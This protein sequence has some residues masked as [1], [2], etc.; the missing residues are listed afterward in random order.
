VRGLYEFSAFLSV[1]G[2][3]LIVRPAIPFVPGES[4]SVSCDDAA[5]SPDA[6]AFEYSFSVSSQSIKQLNRY[7]TAASEDPCIP[8]KAP[9]GPSR[10]AAPDARRTTGA[11]GVSVPSDYP[12]VTV[13]K[14]T[15]PSDGKVFINNWGGTPYI[16]ILENNGDPVFYRRTP[17]RARDF[18]VQP[19]GL[20]TYRLGPPQNVFHGMD[21]TYA[22]TDTFYAGHGYGTDEHDL[23]ILP[24]G[25]ALV[26]ALDHQQIDM[27]VLVPGGRT[28][29]VVIGNHIQE[30]DK[31]HNV[32]FEWRSWDNFE[33]TDARHIDLT[34][35]TIDYVHMNSISVDTDGNIIISSR[36]LSEI[37]K[38]DRSTGTVMWRLGGA[39]NQFTFAGMEGPFSWQHDARALG[40]NTYTIFDNGNWNSPRETRVLEYNLDTTNRGATLVWE[41]RHTPAFYTWWMG[42][43]QRLPGGN[44]VIGWADASLPRLTEVTPAGETVLEL[45]FATP[46]HCYRVFK[47]PWEGKASAPYLTAEPLSVGARLLFPVFGDSSI[48]KYYIYAGRSAHPTTLV[49]SSIVPSI[50]VTGLDTGNHYFRVTAVDGSGK[51]TAFSNEE[52]VYVRNTVPGANLVMNG[53][54]D[55]GVAPWTLNVNG[56]GVATSTVTDGGEYFIGISGGGTQVWNVQL[57]QGNIPLLQGRR[58]IF[59]FDA[60]AESPRTIDA[61]MEQDGGSYINYSR[62][63]AVYIT[64]SMTRINIPF[65][66]QD[67]TDMAARVSLNCGQSTVNVFFDNISVRED[68]ASSVSADLPE[69]PASAQL[70]TPYPNPFNPETE[71]RY[72]LGT[73]DD[74]RIQIFNSLGQ[75]VQ[76]IEESWKMRGEHA[77]RWDASSQPS[78]V[79]FVVLSIGPVRDVDKLLL[80]R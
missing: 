73:D 77:V 53:G 52:E 50:D 4:V 39:K 26:I 62:T 33:I 76:T 46:A 59:S 65:I 71:I 79:Y 38:I 1:D 9:D 36:H 61:K 10:P 57:L 24:N 17:S 22:V 27:S 41:Y 15:A 51:M 43:A 55:A 54:F 68:I 34:G 44:T 31:D 7:A 11:S 63:G 20:L 37:T 72:V 78:G 23:Q 8:D 6:A 18:K 14:M 64:T 21:A 42:N 25:N 49:D 2:N 16:M 60:R 13:H 47:F 74:V 48:Q 58:Y 29:A 69:T 12:S 35:G 30:L 80:I 32:V 56:D 70:L 40:N 3:T 67:A 45:D 5:L 19:T 75:L 28:D 66:M